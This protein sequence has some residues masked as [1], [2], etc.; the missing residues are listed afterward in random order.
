MALDSSELFEL[1]LLDKVARLLVAQ[2]AMVEAPLLPLVQQIAHYG[3]QRYGLAAV[4]F[5]AGQR[6]EAQG[7]APEARLRALTVKSIITF[8]H[9]PS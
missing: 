5:E 1:G 9:E 2:S 3:A 8:Q 4:F 7:A 6:W